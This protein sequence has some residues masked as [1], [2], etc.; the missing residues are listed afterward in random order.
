MKESLFKVLE[1]SATQ[2]VS[3]IALI[4]PFIKADVLADLLKHIAETVHVE[5]VARWIPVEI[6][7]GVCDLEIYDVLAARKNSDLF[8]HSLLHA[9]LYRFD[10][11]AYLGSANL[12]RKALGLAAPT[13]IEL[14]LASNEL[15]ENLKIFEQNLLRNA[16]KV[17]EGIYAYMKRKVAEISGS[18]ITAADLLELE[19][20]L[21]DS[22]W[23]PQ[24]R[25]PERLY[26]VYSNSSRAKRIM[27]ESAFESAQTDLG[28]LR[29]PSGLTEDLFNAEVVAVLGCMPLI[30]EIDG[31]AAEGLN[32]RDA[33]ALISAN[34]PTG[35]PAYS[36]SETWEVL[37][38]W[39]LH[40]FPAHYRR[41]AGDEILK[42]GKVI[43]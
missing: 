20:H 25:V 2:A 17:D 37:K 38:A 10:E 19:A 8:I 29:L 35:G 11:I 18:T 36:P 14:L 12:T 42:K 3:S 1:S 21:L 33:E 31:A 26:Q 34:E 41:E 7:A 30:R 16:M 32:A 24:C 39:L 23:L 4:A 28:A 43:G 40:F 5:V 22:N 15:R 9:K 27:V 6:V 13:N